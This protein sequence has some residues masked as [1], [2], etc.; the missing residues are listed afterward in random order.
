MR[1][2][3]A[4]RRAAQ[5]D[6]GQVEP[7]PFEVSW[8]AAAAGEDG[9]PVEVEHTEVF[10][11]YGEPSMATLTDAGYYADLESDTPEA[12]A[13]IRRI[14]MEAIGNEAEFGRFWKVARVIDNDTLIDIMAGLIEDT[15]GRPTIRPS[16]SSA[17]SSTDGPD[18]KVIS[19]PGGF[20]IQAAPQNSSPSVAASS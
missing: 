8:Y 15:T 11:A 10:H 16:D 18:S 9:E 1:S 17:S 19:L 6:A 5:R 20:S 13:I 14:F 3:K 4:A 7:I 12:M 2:Y